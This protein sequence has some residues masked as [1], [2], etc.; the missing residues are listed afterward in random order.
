MNNS[1][2][3]RYL[4]ITSPDRETIL[5]RNCSTKQIILIFKRRDEIKS[6]H[7]FVFKPEQD[8]EFLFDQ[9]KYPF[10][11]IKE[12]PEIRATVEFSSEQYEQAFTFGSIYY[13]YLYTNFTKSPGPDHPLT[14]QL[15]KLNEYISNNLYY[16]Y[17]YDFDYDF[18]YKFKYDYKNK[19][20]DN[21]NDPK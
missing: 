13:A 5:I 18:K 10:S 2:N 4:K 15:D 19:K 7:K 17:T 1:T 21:D 8:E 16:E 14:K 9:L 3:F 20:K 12:S 11:I 6:L